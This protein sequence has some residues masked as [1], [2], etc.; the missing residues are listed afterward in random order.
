MSAAFVFARLVTLFHRRFKE[1]LTCEGLQAFTSLISG[2]T[3]ILM[4]FIYW[5]SFTLTLHQV[6]HPS[7]FC[8]LCPGGGVFP[9]PLILI[10][11]TI[12]LLRLFSSLQVYCYSLFSLFANF[13]L[14]VMNFHC[15]L[16]CSCF[17]MFN[18]VF[19]IAMKSHVIYVRFTISFNSSLFY[20]SSFSLFYSVQFLAL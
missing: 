9:P 2:F 19:G 4:H 20:S 7:F 6:T 14:E 11:A 13:L 15:F 8:S 17:H 16:L 10:L 1:A 3:N 18:I 5:F 12:R